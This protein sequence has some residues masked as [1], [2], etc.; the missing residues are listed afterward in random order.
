MDTVAAGLN[1]GWL[2][3]RRWGEIVHA[4]FSWGAEDVNVVLGKA[5]VVIELKPD[6]PGGAVVKELRLR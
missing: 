2:G 5:S 6:V 1:V 3:Q 4:A